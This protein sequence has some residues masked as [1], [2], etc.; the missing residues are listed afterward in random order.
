MYKYNR[1][2]IGGGCLLYIIIAFVLHPIV[3]AILLIALIIMWTSGKSKS[4]KTEHIKHNTEN[5]NNI[6][7]DS[8]LIKSNE[9]KT[10]QK[11]I[12][13]TQFFTKRIK[14][15]GKTL[16]R[17]LNGIRLTEKINGE[18]IDAFITILNAED[19]ATGEII[20]SGILI[21][22]INAKAN[23]LEH[24]IVDISKYPNNQDDNISENYSEEPSLCREYDMTVLWIP[25][26]AEYRDHN[27]D[28]HNYPKDNIFLLQ[29]AIEIIDEQTERLKEAAEIF[30]IIQGYSY[31]EGNA[32]LEDK[33]IYHS[34]LQ[35][36]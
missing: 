9:C 31:N 4:S 26:G 2:N 10:T 22:H 5:S 14:V 15:L 21:Q 1:I 35:S 32:T 34:I 19:P 27:G 17:K 13:A 18:I 24:L 36:R 25:A 33:E 3:G 29:T 20:T 8:A 11:H 28:W 6:H 23:G 30:E 16:Y 12:E 7:Q